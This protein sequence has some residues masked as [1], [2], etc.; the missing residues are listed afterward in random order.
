MTCDSLMW[1]IDVHHSHV[2]HSCL[3]IYHTH[4]CLSID[5]THSCLSIYDTCL[6]SCLAITHDSFMWGVPRLVRDLTRLHVTSL[7]WYLTR[8]L[9]TPSYWCVPS[10][11]AP[12]VCLCVIWLIHAWRDICDQSDLT[13]SHVAWLI[14]MWHHS[15]KL[16]P[17]HMWHDS[18][19]CKRNLR[20]C[21]YDTWLSL[22]SVTHLYVIWPTHSYVMRSVFVSRDSFICHVT[23][24][25]VIWPTHSYVMRLLYVWRDSFIGKCDTDLCM[26]VCVCM[27]MHIQYLYTQTYV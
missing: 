9:A 14:H 21:M 19:I 15:Y 16:L 22:A 1:L 24:V 11:N 3:S 26:F 17:I 13:H 8:L 25:C 2:T 18:C 27:C 7:G 10:L 23:H 12:R 6:Y 4:S 20:M 5:H